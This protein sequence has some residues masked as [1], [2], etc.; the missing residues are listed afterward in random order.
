V[1]TTAVE[2]V[3]EGTRDVVEKR[4]ELTNEKL[5]VAVE[6][7]DENTGELVADDVR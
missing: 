3:D 4:S 1:L 2:I 6:V 7:V 5:V